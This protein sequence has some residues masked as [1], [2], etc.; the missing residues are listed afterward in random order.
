M[1]RKNGKAKYKLNCISVFGRLNHHRILINIFGQIDCK[2]NLPKML[3]V[4]LER[5]FETILLLFFPT[6]T[7][8]ITFVFRFFL[9]HALNDYSWFSLEIEPNFSF[10]LYFRT[11]KMYLQHVNNQVFYRG[12]LVAIVEILKNT[13]YR[14]MVYC[15]DGGPRPVLGDERTDWGLF[16]SKVRLDW[17]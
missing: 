13:Y 6:S 15:T 10:F 4:F 5:L 12:L 11:S 16:G 7:S 8:G 3:L 9:F 14:T 1:L 17:K 2:I